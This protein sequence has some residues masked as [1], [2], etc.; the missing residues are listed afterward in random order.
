M[1]SDY[2]KLLSAS[3]NETKEERAKKEYLFKQEFSKSLAKFFNDSDISI[4]EIAEHT[5]YTQQ[6][7]SNLKRGE[8]T[9]KVPSLFCMYRLATSLNVSPE[10]LWNFDKKFQSPDKDEIK[11]MKKEQLINKIKDI[12]D[13]AVL[14]K[15][16]SDIDFI[17]ELSYKN[18][19][20][21]Y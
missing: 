18:K 11:E 2:K 12:D 14:D 20:F 1:R 8:D 19:N 9:A 7:C 17:S 3:P 10:F 4:K 5:G 15:L 16:L 21:E 6:H 13:D